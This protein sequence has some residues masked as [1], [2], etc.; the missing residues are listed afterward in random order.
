MTENNFNEQF[1]LK[2]RDA[3]PFLKFVKA[4]YTK[5]NKTVR[6]DFLRSTSMYDGQFNDEMRKEVERFVQAVMPEGVY[7]EIV[8]NKTYADENT[9]KN[10]VVQY[11]T[12]EKQALTMQLKDGDVSVTVSGGRINV[13]IAASESM[14]KMLK[15]CG[16][17]ED[18]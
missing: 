2:T 13:K 14:I 8:Y 4:V 18:L 3:Y 6:L 9:V 5:N 17:S 10:K 11:I 12:R 16:F 15:D 1:Q 7:Y